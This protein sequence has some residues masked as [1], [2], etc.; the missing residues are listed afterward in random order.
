MSRMD[1]FNELV[2]VWCHCGKQMTK[3]DHFTCD[4]QISGRLDMG[5]DCPECGITIYTYKLEPPY[6]GD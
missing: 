5:Y 3:G 1:N 4:S 2:N 6:E